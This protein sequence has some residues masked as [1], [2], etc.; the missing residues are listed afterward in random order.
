MSARFTFV[1]ARRASLSVPFK[2]K[3][4]QPVRSLDKGDYVVDTPTKSELTIR[5]CLLSTNLYESEYFDCTLSDVV[6]DINAMLKARLGDNAPPVRI[7]LR[8]GFELPPLLTMSITAAPAYETLCDIATKTK[9]YIFIEEGEV[10]LSRR[11][12]QDS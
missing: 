10:V 1:H 2:M 7:D 11:K 12:Q 4:G 5:K 3:R 6:S 9:L 8:P